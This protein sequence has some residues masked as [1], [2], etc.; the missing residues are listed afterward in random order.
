MTELKLEE[1]K[2]TCE[3]KKKELKEALDEYAS[4]KLEQDYGKYINKFTICHLNDDHFPIGDKYVFIESISYS[5]KFV[6][7]I[8]IQGIGFE[9]R[10]GVSCDVTTSLRFS[11][12][13]RCYIDTFDEDVEIEIISEQEWRDK[14][15]ECVSELNKYV[16]TLKCI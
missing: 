11:F 4:A 14:Y 13:T 15:S 3:K 1:L 9:K 6:R 12:D 16:D 5:P 7:H 10:A 2:A 8:V